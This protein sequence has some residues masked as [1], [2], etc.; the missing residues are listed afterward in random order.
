MSFFRGRVRWALAFG[1]SISAVHGARAQDSTA[2]PVQFVMP[3]VDVHG[4]LEI[5]YR[6]GDPLVKDGYR[7]R[8]ADLKFSGALTPRLRW[9]ITF[10]AG[11]AEALNTST[12]TKTDSAA[13]AA[14]SVDQRSRMLQDAALTYTV[15]KFAIF[16]VG[17][18]IVPL[19]LEGTLNTWNVETVERANFEV[20]RSRAV[21]LGDVRDIGVSAN[22]TAAGLEYHVGMFD[23]MGDA[24]G[25]TDPNQEKS[26]LARLSY[27]APFFPGFQIGGT[28][29]LQGGLP[30]QKKERAA[31]EVQYRNSRFVLRGETMA[32]RDG[33]LRRFGWYGLGA[34]RLRPDFQLVARFDSWD[35]DTGAE[36]ALSNALQQQVVGGFA[37]FIENGNAKLAINVI[38]QTF[39]NISTVRD[40]TIGLFAFQAIF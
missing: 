4:F 16:D 37:Y 26:V 30:A 20:E 5:Y 24:G 23:E 10:D 12:G 27:H 39:P 8:K 31:T 32:A 11:K 22:G 25:G 14:V 38:R 33:L 18:Q 3:P 7:L 34:Y 2:A 15:N 36:S 6:S 21:G 9:R 29:G 35:R 1:T 28:G 40:A 17:Q 19:S 13:V